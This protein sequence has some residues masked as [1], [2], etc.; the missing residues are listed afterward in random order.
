MLQEMDTKVNFDNY[1]TQFPPR[2]EEGI[3]AKQAA[4]LRQLI[5]QIGQRRYLKIKNS[6]GLAGEPP[7]ALSR[8]D[9]ARLIAALAEARR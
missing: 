8:D 9:A 7:L 2:Q 4:Y 3:T 5:G 6:L 1:T